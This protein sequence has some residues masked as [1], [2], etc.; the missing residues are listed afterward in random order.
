[1]ETWSVHSLYAESS[2]ILGE[3]S[4]KDLQLYSLNLRSKNLPVIFSIG[5]LSHITGSECTFFHQTI[6][7]KREQ[8]NYRIYRISKRSGGFRY[9]H[10]VNSKLLEVQKF[11]NSH[12]LQK[13][14]PHQ[15]SM[16]YHV[17][18][19]GIRHCAQVHCRCRWLFQ[20][21]LHDFFWDVTEIDVFNI[22]NR[23]GYRRLLSF[24]MARLCTT[25]H[26]PRAARSKVLHSHRGFDFSHAE[27][28]TLPYLRPNFTAIGVL[29]QGSPTSPMLA[30][31][32][33]YQLDCDLSEL[34]R[35]HGMVYTRYADDLCFSL[36]RDPSKSEIQLIRNS[37]VKAISNTGFKV[38]KKKTRIARPGSRKEVVGLLVN[39]DTPLLT[40]NT[41]GRIDRFIYAIQKYGIDAVAKHDGFDSSIGL[42]NHLQ[43]LVAFA[44]DVDPLHGTAFRERFAAISCPLTQS[45][46]E[47]LDS[48]TDPDGQQK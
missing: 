9:I 24:E 41:R 17:G 40:R 43:G 13:A 2:K 3:N 15:A 20:F 31:L 47:P 19:G 12:I 7:R 32:A 34:A 48:T 27:S 38:N 5:H 4:A 1:M 18:T 44:C 25:T 26:L 22:F 45:C 36:H 23:L 46:A 37:I 11:I 10:A 30:N 35:K 8:S 39:V 16:A 42:Y 21:D 6:Q 29:P 14:V 33:A 28:S